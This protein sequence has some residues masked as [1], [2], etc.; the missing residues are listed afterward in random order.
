MKTPTASQPLRLR[1][2][3]N[4]ALT[5]VLSIAILVMVN[6]LGYKYY[7]RQDLSKSGYYQLSEK[8]TR[9]LRSLTEPVRITVCLI[10]N[11]PVRTEIDN[12]LRQY[13]YVGGDRLQIEYV[14][15]ALHLDRAEALAKRLK[16]DLRENVVI[17][18]Y[19]GRHKFVNDKDIVDYDMSGAMLGQSPRIKAFKGEQ[20]FTAAILSL[21]EGK[22]LKVYVTTGHGEREFGNMSAPGGYGEIDLRIRR[23]NVETIPLDLA[24][25]PMVPSDADAVIIAGPKVPFRPSEVEAI[26]KY[27][28]AKGKLLLLEGAESVSGL[29]PLLAKYGIRIDND[30][31][32][33][34]GKVGGMTGDILITTALGTHYADHPA[35]RGLQGLSLQMPDARSLSVVPDKQNPNVAKVV[36]LVETPQVFWGETDPSEVASQNPK[37]DPGAD[38]PGPLALAMLFDGGELPGQ[39]I[40]VIGTRIV[41]IGSSAFLVNQYIDGVA[42]DFFLNVLNWMLK[43]EMALGISPKVAQE[44]SLSVPAFQRESAGSFALGVVP[45]V[46][47]LLGVAVYFA[48]RK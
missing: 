41:A 5:I 18:E 33:A 14:D 22:P 34:F 6:Y 35:V 40:H 39:G 37:R 30:Q 44:F 1:L 46:C 20:Q 8:T 27:V 15:P 23:E 42:V 3:L 24:E 4:N 38:I 45:L 28:E 36:S 43:R 9:I 11:S 47:A 12:L 32:V 19:R 2:R 25:F 29:E 16:F 13:K 26:A 31:V 17:F 7:Y 10:N 48:R 21:V